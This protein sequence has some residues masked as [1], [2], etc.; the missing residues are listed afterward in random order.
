MLNGDRPETEIVFDEDVRAVAEFM[1]ANV[2]AA[3]LVSVASAVA[4]IAP[5]LWGHYAQ[6]PVR[7]LTLQYAP[8]WDQI[9]RTQSS[10]T[11]LAPSCSHAG[12]G[13]AG[14]MAC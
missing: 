13:S 6:E 1:L 4:Q 10:A 14:E 12:D 11:K 5:V 9:R 2:A 7:A 8:I 3:K